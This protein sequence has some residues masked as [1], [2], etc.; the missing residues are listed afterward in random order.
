LSLLSFSPNTSLTV[1]PSTTQA[2]AIV[3]GNGHYLRL[4]NGGT[5]A[6]YVLFYESTASVP[7][8]VTTTAMLIPA[9]AIE[10]FSVA[11]D[12]TRVAYLGDASGTTLNISRGEGQ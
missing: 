10:I 4:C 9:G 1:S 7:T 5:G 11:S 8:V 3:G 6:A 2:Q 12:T